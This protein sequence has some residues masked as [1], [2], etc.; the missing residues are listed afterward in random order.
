MR[1]HPVHAQFPAGGIRF[2]PGVGDDSDA[3]LQTT[4]VVCAFHDKGMCNAGQ[5]PDL[6]DVRVANFATE[7]RAFLE[8]GIEHV[9]EAY[10]AAKQWLPR[11]NL[12]VVHAGY[13]RPE[14]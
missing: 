9:V 3:R 6:F 13:K 5:L 2:P 1:G 14:Q 4:R 10:I 8:D 11:V 7:R 12:V